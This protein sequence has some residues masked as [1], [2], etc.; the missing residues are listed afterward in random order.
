MKLELKGTLT[1]DF[2][3]LAVCIYSAYKQ[4]N[5]AC[6]F[7][8]EFNKVFQILII[9]WWLSWGGVAF[10]ANRVNAE[11][12]LMA[13]EP[14]CSEIH[15]ICVYAG[16]CNFK[17]GEFKKLLRIHVSSGLSLRGMSLCLDHANMESCS[18]RT[19][20]VPLGW[21]RAQKIKE[22]SGENWRTEPFLT[23][24]KGDNLEKICIEGS[25]GSKINQKQVD[26]FIYT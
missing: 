18:L 3:V 10:P 11:W 20:N 14:K 15:V 26:F 16:D 24:L 17:Y 25:H 2:L 23:P 13:N 7:I 4:K 8:L 21:L 9:P 1:G 12:D 5:K 6:E 19:G 22:A